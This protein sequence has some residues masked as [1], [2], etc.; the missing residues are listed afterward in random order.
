MGHPKAKNDEVTIAGLEWPG[1]VHRSKSEP[2]IS[3]WVN[4]FTSKSPGRPR[5][6][7]FTLN[8]D[9]TFAPHRNVA[10]CH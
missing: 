7:R 9:K 5:N 4:R 3:A 6:V 2:P 8:S 10:L 1:G